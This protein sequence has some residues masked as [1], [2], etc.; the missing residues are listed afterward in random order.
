MD[1]FVYSHV[2]TTLLG[3]CSFEVSFEIRYCESSIS[4]NKKNLSFFNIV[5]ARLGLL[6]IHQISRS[7]MSDSLRPHES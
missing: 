5:L 3:Y 7:V 6:H 2:N 1:P 4:F